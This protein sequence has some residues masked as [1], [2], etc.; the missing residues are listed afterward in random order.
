MT[1]IP[2]LSDNDQNIVIM[3]QCPN[4]D[5]SKNL[6]K[7]GVI[8]SVALLVIAVCII[9]TIVLAIIFTMT[10]KSNLKKVIVIA[11][12][13]ART[14]FFKIPQ[15]VVP[16]WQCDLPQK[17]S[18]DKQLILLNTTTPT[19]CP[20]GELVKKGFQQHQEVGLILKKDYIDSGFIQS[21][22]N[23]SEIKLRSTNTTRTRASL[24]GQLSVL[25]PNNKQFDVEMVEN[26]N[27]GYHPQWPCTWQTKLKENNYVKYESDFPTKVELNQ[28]NGYL[29]TTNWDWYMMW[30]SLRAI[31]GRGDKLP[32]VVT[33]T[34]YKQIEKANNAYWKHW[35]CNADKND[36]VKI[37]QINIGPIF[38]D[39][40]QKLTTDTQK[41]SIITAHDTTLAPLM[42]VLTNSNWNCDQPKFAAFIQIE[43]NKQD[44][45]S[46]KYLGK[47]VNTLECVGKSYCTMSELTQLFQKYIVSGQ[48]RI[49]LCEST[50][51]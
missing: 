42:T 16:E 26:L 24:L 18:Y 34:V 3:H 23:P 51:I 47:Q 5:H 22:Y 9:V 6:K 19:P 1:I 39:I 40:I 43:M 8:I 13:G 32:S 46:V 4:M 10:P 33:D 35:F 28:Y 38:S 44:Q 41:M 11:R 48:S 15:S 14:S 25:F 7:R 17:I 45:I 36:M 20:P 37:V 12:H 2:A 49:D 21:N 50:N 31:T 27:D 29:K 30:D